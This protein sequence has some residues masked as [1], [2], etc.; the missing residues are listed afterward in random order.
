MKKYKLPGCS[1]LLAAVIG[2]R[3]AYEWAINVLPMARQ[4]EDGK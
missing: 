2:T 1:V 4:M 3:R